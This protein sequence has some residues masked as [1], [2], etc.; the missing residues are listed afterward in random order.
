MQENWFNNLFKRWSFILLA[1]SGI[2]WLAIYYLAWCVMSLILPSDSEWL[3]EIIIYSILCFVTQC[4][5]VF[6]LIIYLFL[7]R[8]PDFRIRNKVLV[9]L[10]NNVIYKFFVIV[11]II[12]E[13]VLF[14]YFAYF[15]CF[16]IVFL[17]PLFTAFFNNIIHF[18]PLNLQ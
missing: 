2:F 1:F 15:A 17:S 11:S 6:V 5:T 18:Y 7:E 4:V 14:F 3:F 16:A 8:N 10:S 13:I 9:N 12:L